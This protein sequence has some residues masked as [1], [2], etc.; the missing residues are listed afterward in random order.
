MKRRIVVLLFVVCTRAGA[1]TTPLAK[2]K[3]EQVGMSSERLQRLH[4]F[5][6]R[7]IERG[8]LAGAVTVVT[9]RGKLVDFEAQGYSDLESHTP[10]R[11]DD[12][13]RLA[14][15]TKPIATVAALMLLEE[16][17]FLLEEPLS[18][19]L[20]EFREMK[21]GIGRPG[22]PAFKVMA[23]EREVTIHDIFTHRSGLAPGIA[24]NGAPAGTTQ[25]SPDPNPLAQRVS[26]IA[27]TPLLFQ[28]G[29]AWNYGSSTD[30]LGYLTEVL[31]GQS[32][33]EFLRSRIFAPIGMADTYFRLPK[34]KLPRLASTYQKP[35][36]RGL[37]KAANLPNAVEPRYYSAAGGLVSTPSDYVR[38]CQMLVNGGELDGR[39]YLS[40]K[41]LELMTA[42]SWSPIP[43]SFLQ[44]QYFGLG[45]AVKHESTASGLLGSPGS[46]GWSGAYNTYFRIDPKEQLVMILFVQLSP[47]NNMPLQYGFHNEVMQA[48]AD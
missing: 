41:T 35:A 45:V 30:V 26:N 32:L 20:P 29:S 40:R 14:S 22:D 42:S 38:F 19:Y 25:P 11:T 46:Y 24:R 13:F 3:P 23:L 39:R 7:F 9:R 47:A 5:I 18:K 34:E 1:Q 6:G 12:I 31:S 15:M 27:A 16:G 4:S 48:I 21:V 33:D 43:L 8:E 17:R 2:A 37:E 10:M 36:G 44:G 28:P